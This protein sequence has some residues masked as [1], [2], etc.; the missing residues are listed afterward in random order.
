MH[1]ILQSCYCMDIPRGMIYDEKPSLDDFDIDRE[2]TVDY[3]FYEALQQVGRIDESW[4][5]SL[6]REYIYMFNDA[7][8]ISLLALRMRRPELAFDHLSRMAG[9]WQLFNGRDETVDF[10][11]RRQLV[12]SMVYC[13]VSMHVARYPSARHFL[14]KLQAWLADDAKYSWVAD[15]IT[16]Q[17]KLLPDSPLTAIP[18][19]SG[20]LRS[21]MWKHYLLTLFNE[22]AESDRESQITDTV[23]MLGNST[24]DK[25][26]VIDDMA[27]WLHGHGQHALD[28]LEQLRTKVKDVEQEAGTGP[29][30]QF[31]TLFGEPISANSQQPTTDNQSNNQKVRM[32]LALRL[33]EKAGITEAVLED[34]HGNKEKAAK[35]LEKLLGIPFTTCKRY[36]S[37]HDLSKTYHRKAIDQFNQLLSELGSDIKL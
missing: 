29:G 27:E 30:L 1:H 34:H 33:L 26:C 25:L 18:I 13:L 21:L 6:E 14:M 31:P 35:L 24:D 36:L 2:G 17:I 12:L 37:E 11:L 4:P 7:Y 28:I 15:N 9:E 20:L 16:S 10:P 22:V 8:Y 3:A 32:E 23:M 5:E 19:T